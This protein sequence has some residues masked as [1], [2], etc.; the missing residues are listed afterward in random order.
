MSDASL[1]IISRNYGS[2]S[3]R[4]WLLCEFA[5]L[6]VDVVAAAVD[7]DAARA[8]LL[9]LSP[10]YLVPRLEH[11]DTIAWGI[12]AIAEH[13]H[14]LDLPSVTYP[15]ER[16]R[17]AHCRSV[18]G[19]MVSGFANLRSALPM[20]IRAQYRGFNVLSGAQA[21]IDRIAAIWRDCLDR[22]GGP[23]LFG[24]DPTAADAMY[25]PVCARFATYDVA[26]DA[27]CGGYRDTLLAHPAMG[28]WIAAAHAESEH[29]EELD[30][31]F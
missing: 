5:G 24:S 25:A 11:G 23:W 17:R 18:C 27:V 6:E 19:E 26:L 21:D 31:E 8:E 3:L 15:L 10:S 16:E 9:L 29:V 2:W 28:E 1:T 30:A 22:Y 7:D 20:N 4:G 13:L 12:W 14:E